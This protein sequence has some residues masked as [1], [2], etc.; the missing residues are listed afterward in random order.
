[1]AHDRVV[2]RREPRRCRRRV[3][4]GGPRSRRAAALPSAIATGPDHGQAVNP[5]DLEARLAQDGWT[6][7][8]WANGPGERYAAHRHGYDKVLVVAEG[9]IR[10]GLPDSGLD[11]D[12]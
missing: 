12:L 8:A 9:A 2:A 11:L 10:F 6:A 3:A 7:S 1:A 4:G 5:T